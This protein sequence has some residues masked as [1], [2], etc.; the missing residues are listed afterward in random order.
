MF[1]IMSQDFTCENCNKTFPV[2]RYLKQH[3]KIHKEKE[4]SC[5]LCNKKF[6]QKQRLDDHK[7]IIHELLDVMIQC[8]RCDKLFKSKHQ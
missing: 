1:D 6:R 5:D 4:F 7:K 2:K 8:K 3:E